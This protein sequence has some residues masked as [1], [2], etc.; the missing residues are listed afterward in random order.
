MNLFFE[1][2]YST[3]VYQGC[4]YKVIWAFSIN[5]GIKVKSYYKILRRGGEKNFPWKLIWRVHCLHG[6]LC[7]VSG[8]G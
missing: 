2:L 7:L 1:D 5:N 6:I 3:K 8:K 4:A